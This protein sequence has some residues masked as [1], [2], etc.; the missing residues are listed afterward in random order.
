MNLEARLGTLTRTAGGT[1][2]WQPTLYA[3]VEPEQRAALAELLDSGAVDSV[4]DTCAEQLEELLSAR[5]PDWHPD[6]GELAAAVADHLG[7]RP[8]AEYGT[9]AW[10]A[11]SRQLVRVLRGAE[12]RALRRCR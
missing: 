3:P 6:A 5:R 7:G 9:W 1:A 2:P 10:Y 8:P 11:W 12:H 4:H